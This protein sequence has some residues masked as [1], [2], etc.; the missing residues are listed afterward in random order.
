[1]QLSIML[2]QTY[3]VSHFPVMPVMMRGDLDDRVEAV[4]EDQTSLPQACAAKGPGKGCGAWQ[5]ALPAAERLLGG[6]KRRFRNA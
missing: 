5:T 2:G 6:G 1:M 3:D 4:D